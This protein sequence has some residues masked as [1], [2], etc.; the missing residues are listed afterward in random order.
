[1]RV[2]LRGSPRLQASVTLTRRPAS[3]SRCSS[4][5]CH[6]PACALAVNPGL[7]IGN[8]RSCSACGTCGLPQTACREAWPN[9]LEYR[10]S[11]TCSGNA[12]GT[13]GRIGWLLRSA[14]WMVSQLQQQ[15]C[16]GRSM[17]SEQH[18]GARARGYSRWCVCAEGPGNGKVVHEFR[19]GSDARDLRSTR[20]TASAE[21]RQASS[22]LQGREHDRAR[23]PGCLDPDPLQHALHSG[24]RLARHVQRASCVETLRPVACTSCWLCARLLWGRLR[25]GLELS[26]YQALCDSGSVRK[27][28]QN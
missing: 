6:P 4:C 2:P 15:P 8:I 20:S 23:L 1:M 5:L 21:A 28:S 26:S 9:A 11:Y 14:C 19:C 17:R 16:R 18:I 27:R 13:T 3:T 22:S 24:D 25:R 10:I 12:C 7:R